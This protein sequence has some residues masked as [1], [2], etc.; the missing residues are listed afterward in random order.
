MP[1][2]TG[3][4]A[5]QKHFQAVLPQV[6][7]DICLVQQ[8][9]PHLAFQHALLMIVHWKVNTGLIWES[10]CWG[11]CI[12]GNDVSGRKTSEPCGLQYV[13]SLMSDLIFRDRSHIQTNNLFPSLIM[14]FPLACKS[15][16]AM[17]T[18]ETWNI[19]IKPSCLPSDQTKAA[20]SLN[21]E[22][23]NPILKETH[24]FFLRSS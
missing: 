6:R 8:M 2:P 22:W 20:R 18:T 3:W 11:T 10:D 7:K 14:L 15:L 24:R 1:C 5:W 21:E 17:G 9:L 23:N 16:S 13:L 19:Y 4:Y 12:W